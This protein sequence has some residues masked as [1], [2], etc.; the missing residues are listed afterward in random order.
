MRKFDIHSHILYGVDDGAKDLSESIALI[1]QEVQECVT[2]IFLTPHYEPGRNNA[3]VPELKEKADIIRQS[4]AQEG[5]NVNLYL[6]NEIL[7]S[8]SVVEDI[9]SGKALTLAGTK[10]VLL[11]FTPR[12]DEKTII[13]AVSELQNAGY[14]PIIAHIERI[15]KLVEDVSLI[16]ELRSRNVF[17]QINVSSLDGGIFSRDAA[18]VRNLLNDGLV[19]FLGTDC[20]SPEFRPAKFGSVQNKLGKRID[21]ALFEKAASRNPLKLLENR[22]I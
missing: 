4:C 18:K 13:H 9:K 8:T 20:H 14:L 3:G 10:Y 21:A 15:I 5:L 7:Y 6:G 22:Y 2:D 19:D 1:R 11:E 16:D 12:C 17:T